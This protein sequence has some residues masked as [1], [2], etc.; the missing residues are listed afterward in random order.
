MNEKQQSG[1]AGDSP[2]SPPRVHPHP[3][4]PSTELGRRRWI[5]MARRILGP[6]RFPSWLAGFVER[7]PPC[8]SRPA[9]SRDAAP[10]ASHT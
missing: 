2:D 4:D 1:A 7:N 8:S 9:S 10:A 6:E 3:F 5:R